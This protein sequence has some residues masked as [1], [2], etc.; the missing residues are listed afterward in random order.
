MILCDVNVLL[1][2]MVAAT[3]HHELCRRELTRLRR[4][5]TQIAV[6]EIVSAAVVRIATHAKVFRPAVAPADAFAFV[7]AWSGHPRVVRV[8]PGERHWS[9]F[10]DLVLAT[11]LRGS[12]TTDAYLAA[13]AIEHG[14]EWWTTDAGFARFGA[15]RSR[16]LL[17]G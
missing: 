13:L 5:R 16:N 7:D 11:G 14:C 15:L 9:I 4:G 8:A 1:Y 12:D 17:G 3:P 2:A 6:S 10:R